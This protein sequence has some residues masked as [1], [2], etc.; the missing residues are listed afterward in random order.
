ME[1]YNIEELIH[2]PDDDDV[3]QNPWVEQGLL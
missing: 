1:D 2:L 3:K